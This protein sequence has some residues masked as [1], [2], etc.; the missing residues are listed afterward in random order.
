[1]NKNPSDVIRLK[2]KVVDL[3]AGNFFKVE[4]DRG[5]LVKAKTANQLKNERGNKIRIFERDKVEV[6]INISDIKDLSPEKPVVLGRI[7]RKYGQE[8]SKAKQF[9]NLKKLKKFKQ[10]LKIKSLSIL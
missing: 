8:K 3:I 1:M 9:A 5:G 10:F 7:T 2:G 6:E 4:L